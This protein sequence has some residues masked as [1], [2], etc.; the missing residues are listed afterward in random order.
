[1]PKLKYSLPGDERY[2]TMMSI[3]GFLQR[4]GEIHID[5][6][7]KHFD[8]TRETA[9][10]L[11]STLN[12][13]SFLPRNAEEQLPFF[14][15]LERIED[16]DGIVALGLDE[17][18]QGVPRISGPQS[19]ALLSGL[20]YLSSLPEFEDSEEVN[21]LIKLLSKNQKEIASIEID[22][23]TF[24]SDLKIIRKA[25]LSNK[26]IECRY[27]NNQN[28][29]T[30]RQIDPLALT[31]VEERWY[32]RGY[33]HTK[34]ELRTFRLDHM[35][36]AKILNQD[37]VDRALQLARSLDSTSPI[38][39]A[40]D[41]DTEVLVELSPEA[42]E[43]ASI[44]QEISEPKKV[45]QELIQV[46]IKVGYLPDLG[47]MITKFGQFAKVISPPE[48]RDVVRNFAL[49]MLDENQLEGESD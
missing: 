38:Y 40:S 25:I 37:R 24:D 18:P 48:A 20:Q 5:D 46:K 2:N 10:G 19:I 7:A 44:H 15:D 12:T 31:S 41:N 47:P 32:L 29:E 26:R 4:V 30:V 1:M 14:I 42:Y 8:L 34:E 33:C 21:E 16:E 22:D 11:L 23:V 27:V 3:V 6:L 36:D 35:V 39:S 9:R 49:A 43:L 45:G 28:V 13:T 17:G